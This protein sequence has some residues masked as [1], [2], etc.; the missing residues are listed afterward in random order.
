ML[1]LHV[2][3]WVSLISMMVLGT[4]VVFGQNYPNKPIRIL[5][6]AIGGGSDTVARIIAQGL[7][8]RAGWQLIVD[9]RPGII[10]FDIGSKAQPDGYTLNVAS[11]SLWIGPLM[12]KVPYDAVKD[13]SPIT[14]T[15]GTPTVLVVHSSV[16][17]N[18]IKELIALAKAK[19]GVL[20]YSSSSTGSSSHL[21]AELF[22]SMAGINIVRI[23][24]KGGG[25]ATLALLANEVQMR[26]SIVS[27]ALPHIASGKL[28]GLAVTSAEPSALAPGIPTVAASG[29][30]G[31]ESITIEGVFAPAKTPATIVKRLNEEVVR[32]L[33]R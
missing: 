4:E 2:G 33:N 8:T 13:F 28:R 31:Y 12:Q 23:Q 16:P 9:N 27:G 7:T 11:S 17:V 19:P 14:M 24:Y 21:S 30:P 29:L 18:S 26:F 3:A 22:K 20:N 32:V 6:I 10:S 25:P 15:D 5:T 1:K